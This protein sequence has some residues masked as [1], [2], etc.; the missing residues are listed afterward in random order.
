M[1]PMH[2]ASERLWQDKV[3]QIAKMNS[4]LI[5]HP[6]PHQVR[7][8]VYRSDGKGFPDLCMAHPTKGVLFVELKTETGRLSSD[9]I[10]WAEALIANGIEYYV[11]RPSQIDLIAERLGRS[12]TQP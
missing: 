5:F 10:K 9:Q 11:W 4:W 6:S 2:D 7:P 12:M 3:E 1:P 8:G